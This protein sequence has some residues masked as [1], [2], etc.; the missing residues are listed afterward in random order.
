MNK[1][2]SWPGFGKHTVPP[3]GRGNSPAEEK[4]SPSVVQPTGMHGSTTALILATGHGMCAKESTSLSP[5]VMLLCS[6]FLM[7]SVHNHMFNFSTKLSKRMPSEHLM[8][9]QSSQNQFPTSHLKQIRTDNQSLLLKDISF[10]QVPK[11][12][13]CKYSFN[14]CSSKF[15]SP[16]W[17]C[18]E[19]H[20]LNWTTTQF[21]KPSPFLPSPWTPQILPETSLPKVRD[22]QLKPPDRLH[23]DKVKRTTATEMLSPSSHKAWVG[24]ST[25]SCKPLH[26]GIQHIKLSSSLQHKS[27]SIRRSEICLPCSLFYP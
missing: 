21:L 13:T 7:A 4:P 12:E 2:G 3:V 16:S 25:Y 11:E 14:F 10:T 20:H 9:L 24:Y 18:A 8:I 26:P 6:P 17:N 5:W 19:N 15:L 27:F 22:S 1:F 23:Q